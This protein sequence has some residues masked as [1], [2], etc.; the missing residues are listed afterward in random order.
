MTIVLYNVALELTRMP[1]IS[2]EDVGLGVASFFAVSLGGVAF[3]IMCGFLAAIITR[4]TSGLRGLIP[5]YKY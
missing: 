5:V 2:A 4:F 3:G 1:A